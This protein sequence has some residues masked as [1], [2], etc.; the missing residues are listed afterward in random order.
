MELQDR[1]EQLKKEIAPILEA[2]G[3]E[4]IELTLKRAGKRLMLR[5]LA[6]KE[7]GITIDEC[8]LLN[9]KIGD[10]I[11]EKALI[12]EKHLLE[13]SSPGLDRPL[14]AKKDFEKVLG[15]EIEF[16]LAEPVEDKAYLSGIA[17]AADEE[18]VTIEYK[19]DENISIPYDNINKA[20]RKI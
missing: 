3:A 10:L 14:R 15:E 4:I 9:R 11:E 12:N 19:E 1:L 16:W 18:N 17:R 13:I 2:S 8:A 20:R 7:G 5:L 6:D